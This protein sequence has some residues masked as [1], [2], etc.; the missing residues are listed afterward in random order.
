MEDKLTASFRELMRRHRIIVQDYLDSLCLYI[1]QPRVLFYLEEN[2]GISQTEL[3]KMLKI[4]KEATSVSL[5]RLENA[6]FIERKECHED[7]R[8]N[9]LYLSKKGEEVVRDLRQN[10]DEIN[11]SMFTDLNDEEKDLLFD[12]LFKMNTSLERRLVD[13]KFI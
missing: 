5:R 1:G 11:N 2:P 4:S 12:L 7:R 6:E 8:I 3:S 9:L 10:F 13:E